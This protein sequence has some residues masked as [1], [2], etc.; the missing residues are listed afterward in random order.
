MKVLVISHNSFSQT[1]NNGKTLS[2]LFSAFEKQELCQLYFSPSGSVDY[3]RCENYYLIRDIDALKSVFSRRRCGS[4]K[5]DD[6][7]ELPN[8]IRRSS[9]NWL[10]LLL[11]SLVWRMSS[12]YRGGLDSWL[13]K[14]NPDI[15]FYVGGNSLFSHR[16]ACSLSDELNIPLVSYF[17]DDYVIFPSPNFYTKILKKCY[18]RTISRSRKLYVIGK[19]MAEEYSHYY[20]REF[21]PI[22]NI[23]DVPRVKPV[24]KKKDSKLSI[25]YFGGIGW[26]RDK[27]ILRFA[28]FLRDFIEPSLSKNVSL[29]IYTFGV[30]DGRVRNELLKYN[31]NI[32]NGLTG[33]ELQSAM[34]DSDIFLHVESIEPYYC[35]L[36]KLSVST[37]IPEYMGLAKPIIAFGPIQLASFGVISEVNSSLVIN[38][39]PELIKD[40]KRLNSIIQTLNSDEELQHISDENYAYALSHFNRPVV[41]NQFKNDLSNLI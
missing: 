17:T 11:R 10:V 32:H 39:S 3:S 25:N 33:N 8:G 28:M 19:K 9:A 2:S 7:P 21:L 24:Y 22:M 20:N 23:I 5:V 38:D 40:K 16:I 35:S 36:T 41:A 31:V 13:T 30:I 34:K 27:E 18:K 26:A 1:H 29:G 15:L 6:I 37:K 14:Q 4:T 12:W